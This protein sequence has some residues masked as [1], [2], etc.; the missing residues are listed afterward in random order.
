M[1]MVDS[2]L[3]KLGKWK[4]NGMPVPRKRFDKEIQMS[5]QWLPTR[6]M[7]DM[8]N[9]HHPYNGLQKTPRTKVSST[10]AERVS[11]T[12]VE[13][14]SSTT[15]DDPNLDAMIEKMMAEFEDQPS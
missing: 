10:A 12:A 8:W 15:N 13:G 14:V 1:N 9:V 6:S 3:F 11:S 5:G 7:S 2:S 4:H